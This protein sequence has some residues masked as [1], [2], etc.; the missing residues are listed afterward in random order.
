MMTVGDVLEHKHASLV[1]RQVAAVGITSAERN[2]LPSSLECKAWEALEAGRISESQGFVIQLLELQRAKAG[3]PGISDAQHLLA[4]ESRIRNTL[5]ELGK[6]TP[7]NKFK[8]AEAV[9]EFLW[10][11]MDSPS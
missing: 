5:V 3:A 6:V 11:A 9:T 10:E 2:A 8:V 7:L 1:A 4:V